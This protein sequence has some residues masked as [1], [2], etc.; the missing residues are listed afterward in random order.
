MTADGASRHEQWT[1]ER[2]KAKRGS[3]FRNTFA[4]TT[5]DG[6]VAH[7]ED[8][9]GNFPT[10]IRKSMVDAITK[11]HGTTTAYSADVWLLVKEREQ[12]KPDVTWWS[13]RDPKARFPKANIKWFEPKL[14]RSSR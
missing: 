1:L 12:G 7:V 9:V 5:T 3:T 4:K 2:V 8:Y 11:Q 6:W 14:V 13:H 10:P